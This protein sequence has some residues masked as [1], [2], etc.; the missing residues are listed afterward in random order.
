M[1]EPPNDIIV[2]MQVVRDRLVDTKWVPGWK[3]SWGYFHLNINCIKLEKTILE[4]D[5]IYIPTDTR[6]NLS[7]AHIKKLENMGWWRRLKM[8]S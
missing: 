7:P 4:V 5:D 1:Q 6:L 8:R 2:K 3:K